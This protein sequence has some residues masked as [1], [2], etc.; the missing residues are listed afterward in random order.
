[1]IAATPSHARSR[2]QE[3]EMAKRVGGKTIHRSGAGLVKGD[4]R[5]KGIARIENKTTK[6]ASYG[7]S[8]ETIN[9]LD[10]AVA[11]TDELPILQVELLL[12]A[13]KF[14]VLS[15]RYLDDIITALEF[16]H[17]YHDTIKNLNR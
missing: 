16:Y 12:G 10:D 14:V 6:Y 3:I 5:L 1:M 9:K 11:G 7:V 17:E 15:D 2:A 8:V 13:Y 4:V